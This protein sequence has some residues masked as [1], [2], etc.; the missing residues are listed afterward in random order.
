MSA[1]IVDYG[2]GNLFSIRQACQASGMEA[3][4]TA[5]HQG[6]LEADVVLLPGVGAFGDA[7]KALRRLDL[8]APL[9]AVAASGKLVIGICLGMQL[10]M[11]ESREFGR[12]EGLGLVDGEVVS[13]REQRTAQQRLKVPLIGWHGIRPASGRTVDEW[14][15]TPLEGL[16]D[17]S[18]MYFVHSF[19]A[20][21]EDESAVLSTT[22]YGSLEFCSALRSGN[23]MGFQFH[24]ERS[25]PDGLQIYRNIAKFAK[26]ASA[27]NG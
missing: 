22:T 14:D 21:P 7:M 9:R 11:T 24:P 10:L 20:T 26:I 17:G 16:P 23:V 5:D 2:L 13:L 8:V 27:V 6:L 25:G 4:I 1:A 3:R 12:H 19:H 15:G 18:S